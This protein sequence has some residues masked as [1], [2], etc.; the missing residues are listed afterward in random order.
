MDTFSNYQDHNSVE[1]VAPEAAL[2]PPATAV[3]QPAT[4]E[5]VQTCGHCQ[6]NG[7]LQVRYTYPLLLRWYMIA[8]GFALVILPGMLL[9][10]WRRSTPATLSLT[11]PACLFLRLEPGTALRS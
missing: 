6:Y 5:H 3:D 10:S 2:T 9:L 8:I 4:S 11:C 1:A 7:P